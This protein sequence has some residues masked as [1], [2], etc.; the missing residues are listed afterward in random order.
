MSELPLTPAGLSNVHFN[1]KIMDFCWG[2]DRLWAESAG[3]RLMSD[4]PTHSLWGFHGSG[5]ILIP[6]RCVVSNSTRTRERILQRQKSDDDFKVQMWMDV[7][8][9]AKVSFSQPCPQIHSKLLGLWITLRFLQFCFTQKWS[10]AEKRWFFHDGEADGLVGTGRCEEEQQKDKEELA[11]FCR[12]MAASCR[13]TCGFGLQK[14]WNIWPGF[15]NCLLQYTNHRLNRF[16]LS[17][18][19]SVSLSGLEST[20]PEQFVHRLHWTPLIHLLFVSMMERFFT[21]K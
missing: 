20:S 7:R 2:D 17:G 13:P 3:P 8:S 12:Q 16:V 21:A 14:T 19:G 1:H 15:P 11:R 4:W 6:A 5:C 9:L 18:W 10:R